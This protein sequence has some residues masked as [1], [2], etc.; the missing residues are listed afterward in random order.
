MNSRS[1]KIGKWKSKEDINFDCLVHGFV[2]D[3]TGIDMRYGTNKFLV[4]YQ[5][6]PAEHMQCME[7]DEFH[8]RFEF[9]EYTIKHICG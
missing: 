4:L 2:N 6:N 3:M 7:Y 9:V 8:E 1:V 5:R